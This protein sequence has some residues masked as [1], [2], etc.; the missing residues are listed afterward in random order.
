MLPISKFINIMVIPK[1]SY[2]LTNAIWFTSLVKRV[3][4][5][6]STTLVLLSDNKGSCEYIPKINVN[7]YFANVFIVSTINAKTWINIH[8]RKSFIYIGI[9]QLSNLNIWKMFINAHKKL[10]KLYFE[11]KSYYLYIILF[12]LFLFT[13]Y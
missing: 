1:I 9:F 10:A 6:Q 2:S 12:Y 3:I 5:F 8:Y 13:S 4:N 7:K 11:E